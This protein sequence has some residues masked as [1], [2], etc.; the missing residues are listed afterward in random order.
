MTIMRFIQSGLWTL[1]LSVLFL[2]PV[3]PVLSQTVPVKTINGVP[4]PDFAQ[5]SLG[6]LP[7]LVEGGS[8]AVTDP[9]V[10]AQ[11]GYNPSRTWQAG[12]R[13]DQVM[14]LGDVS[15]VFGL[16]RFS[17]QDIARLGLSES[18]DLDKLALSELKPLAIN[19][20]AD[21]VTALGYEH[22]Y[23]EQVPLLRDI[24][25][26]LY[27]GEVPYATLGQLVRQVPEFAQFSLGALN[28][29]LYGLAALPGLDGLAIGLLRGWAE[30]FVRSIPGLSDVPFAQYLLFPTSFTGIA[31]LVSLPLATIEQK[32]TRTITGSNR[33]GFAVPCERECLHIELGD[34]LRGKQWIGKHQQVRGG[35]G[36]LASLNGGQEPTGRHPFGPWGKVVLTG[37]QEKTGR[38]DFGLYLRVCIKVP[39]AFGAVLDLGCSPYFIGPIPWLP[40]QERSTMFVGPL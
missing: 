25:S 12:D 28:L 38:A 16:E 13:A 3:P 37:V 35:H 31:S 14:M 23:P 21:I 40:T 2:T 5:I 10:L 11:L 9:Y 19:T 1:L 15:E 29:A 30:Q 36:Y 27:T 18:L 33:Q 7:A 8:I 39:L 6:N 20:V 32:R 34:P 26:S 24:L 17:L 22:L 4:M